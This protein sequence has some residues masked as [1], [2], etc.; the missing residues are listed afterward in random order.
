MVIILMENMLNQK[1]EDAL[2]SGKYY[3]L[4]DIINFQ[5]DHEDN[6]IYTYSCNCCDTLEVL[7]SVDK[8]IK[9]S[10]QTFKN[11]I[12][13]KKANC[14]SCGLFMGFLPQHWKKF[15]FPFGKLKGMRLK[16]LRY[17]KHCDYLEW[18]VGSDIKDNLKKPVLKYLETYE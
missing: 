2:E 18:W 15:I 5:L 14:G 10:K 8:P 3:G 7:S 13:H 1:I 12:T 16:N 6:L 9:I 17:D 11:G 4:E